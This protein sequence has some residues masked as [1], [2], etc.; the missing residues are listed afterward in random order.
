MKKENKHRRHPV[1][2]L[3]HIPNAETIAAMEACDR[4]EGL[5]KVTLEQLD[6]LFKNEKKK[7]KKNKS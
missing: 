3:S 5:T 7:R 4:E 6:E 2:K 1:C